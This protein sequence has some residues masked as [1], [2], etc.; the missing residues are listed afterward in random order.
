MRT[1][2]ILTICSTACWAGSVL[3]TWRMDRARSR[4][5]GADQP[6]SVTVR[7]EPH[8]KGRVFTLDRLERDGRNTSFSSVLYLDGASRDFQDFACSGMQSSRWQ[9]ERTIE[10]RR[11][12][13]NGESIWRVRESAGN[14]RELMIE[15]MEKSRDG[16]TLGSRVV[17]KR[18]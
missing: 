11:A 9:D 5:A 8:A 2:L 18:Q 7:I 17:L 4:F 1:I 14:S 3:G 12:C 16:S 15:I 10:I 6:Q 13:S